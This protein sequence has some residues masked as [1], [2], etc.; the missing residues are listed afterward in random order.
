MRGLWSV[1]S[2]CH[3]LLAYMISF[4]LYC[5]PARQHFLFLLLRRKSRLKNWT[6][7]A[8]SKRPEPQGELAT[9]HKVAFLQL[10]TLWG[11]STP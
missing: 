2:V 7:H 10:V 9:L 3:M 8:K 4:N 11:G 1:T 6:T 5:K